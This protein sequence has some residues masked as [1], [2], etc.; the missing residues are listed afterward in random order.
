MSP[1]SFVTYVPDRSGP[2]PICGL[3]ARGPSRSLDRNGERTRVVSPSRRRRHAELREH[4]LWSRSV[5]WPQSSPGP[6]GW[7]FGLAGNGVVV[8]GVPDHGIGVILH[9]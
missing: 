4:S 1:D 8:V 3:S 5:V 6:Q 7:T 9:D 2:S